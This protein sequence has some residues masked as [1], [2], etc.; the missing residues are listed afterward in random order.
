MADITGLC[1]CKW[2]LLAYD[3][4]KLFAGM[5]EI[6]IGEDGWVTLPVSYMHDKGAPT[7]KSRGWRILLVDSLAIEF[8]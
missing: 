6:K 2:E 1:T 5:N 8:H 7:C 4:N 3:E